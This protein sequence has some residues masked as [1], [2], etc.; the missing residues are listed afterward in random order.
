MNRCRNERTHSHTRT[1]TLTPTLPGSFIYHGVDDEELEVAGRR[2]LMTK[3]ME[4]G[5]M[6][7]P[8]K[9]GSSLP[10]EVV[11]RLLRF[12]ARRKFKKAPSQL[13]LNN[14]SIPKPRSS[15]STP[16][17]LLSL[18][19]SVHPTIRQSNVLKQPQ[20]GFIPE[21]LLSFPAADEGFRALLSFPSLE[22]FV[23]VTNYQ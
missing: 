11:I 5:A 17:L 15:P 6:L 10:Q 7:L 20:D 18:P 23:K 13:R 4:D 12:S 2:A 8:W 19:P 16:P 3:M 9:Q 22:T 21:G 1:H 14:H